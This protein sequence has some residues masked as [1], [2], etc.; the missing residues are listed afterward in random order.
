M[1]CDN[2]QML[3]PKEKIE[4]VGKLIHAIQSDNE[5]FNRAEALIK[6]AEKKKLFEGVKINPAPQPDNETNTNNL[7]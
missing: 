2:Y 7:L 4:L 6:L 1:N 5:I 3:L